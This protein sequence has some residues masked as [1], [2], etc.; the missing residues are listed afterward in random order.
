M[1]NK[2]IN[3]LREKVDSLDNKIIALLDERLKLSLNIALEKQKNNLNIYDKNREIN[4]IDRLKKLK[5]NYLSNN[6]I[7]KIYKE[8][9][10]NSV[11]EMEKYK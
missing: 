9:L 8:I 5:K 3:L 1:N 6:A 10:N 4:I 2:E 11:T 7:E